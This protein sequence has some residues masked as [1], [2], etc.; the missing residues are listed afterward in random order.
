MKRRPKHEGESLRVAMVA[1]CAFPSPRGSQVL[2]REVAEALADRGHEVHLVTY[3]H[4]ESLVPLRG[5]FLHRLSAP[6]FATA[7]GGR[8]WRKVVLDLC[9]ALAVYRVVRSER[10][11]VIHAHNYEAPLISFVIR[12]LTGVPVV[13]H[14]HNALSDELA[15]YFRPGMRRRLARV[16]GA[17][18]DRVVPRRADF[19]IALTP[20]LGSFL[21][22]RGVA[23]ERLSVIPP[24]SAPLG[25]SPA[26][27]PS[28]NSGRFVVMYTGNLDPYQDLRVL[29][30]GFAV[31]RASVPQAELMIVTHDSKWAVRTD[32][33]VEVLRR[34]A[35]AQIVVAP[36]FAA[37]RRALAQADILV[38]P[39]S[40]WSGF[41]MKLINYMAAGR[42]L[43]V[44]EGSAK[45][46]VDGHTGLVFRNGDAPG[47]A[48]AL[49]SLMSNPGLRQ[50]LGE[51]ARRAVNETYSWSRAAAQIE[52]IYADVCGRAARQW[53]KRSVARLGRYSGID[54][55]AQRSYK[56]FI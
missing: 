19:S 53:P 50:Q 43:V 13:Y 32:R 31:F 22:A 28:P 36:T 38:C 12:R 51:N 14:S 18:L 15:Y 39:R 10:I 23:A 44:A 3:P 49:H 34:S 4:G 48:A 11:D 52:Q 29:G 1:A 26:W 8:G 41:P 46:I 54:R 25:P 16:V 7:H 42:A 24:G 27:R 30:E 45:G 5:I 37:V 2:I 35:G 20:E 55:K 47:L 56:R 17:F 9:L 21:H 33:A 6:A 40:S